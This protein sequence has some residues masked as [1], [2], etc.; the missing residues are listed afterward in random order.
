MKQRNGYVSNSSSSS[1]IV[2]FSEV[3]KTVEETHSLLFP[4]GETI[5][6]PCD[7][8]MSSLRVAEHVF[9]DL[10][11]SVEIPEL[12]KTFLYRYYDPEIYE[13]KF[14]IVKK[15]R[16]EGLSNAECWAKADEAVRP[17]IEAVFNKFFESNKEMKFYVFEYCDEGGG[18][19]CILE[20][21]DIF[22]AVPHMCISHH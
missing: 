16:A 22:E 11:N 8:G 13:E 14:D 10:E 7:E 17:K 19:G 21:G 4:R 2:G 9:N 3:P 12:I 15:Y 18:V 5:V 20:H 1:F 6:Q